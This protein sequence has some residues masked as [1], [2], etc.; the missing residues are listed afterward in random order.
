MDECEEFSSEFA[1][2]ALN[3]NG[4]SFGRH[5]YCSKSPLKFIPSVVSARLYQV[6]K[7]GGKKYY[8]NTFSRSFFVIDA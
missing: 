1:I 2:E 3:A 4:K 8:A 5:P 7:N 6:L